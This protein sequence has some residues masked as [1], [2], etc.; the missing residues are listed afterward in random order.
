MHVVSIHSQILTEVCKSVN[1]RQLS[2]QIRFFF[3]LN[4]MRLKIIKQWKNQ[5]IRQKLQRLLKL[6][7]MHCHWSQVW[8][9]EL[10][11]EF[12]KPYKRMY[13][14]EWSQNYWIFSRKNSKTSIW[15][16]I[17]RKNDGGS[18]SRLCQ[19]Y[20]Q[21]DW[22]ECFHILIRWWNRTSNFAQYE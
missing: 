4:R 17:R 22:G 8:Y 3:R 11:M 1:H 2:E 21:R 15:N 12:Q 6:N 13:L 5:I 7:R 19:M 9:I 10:S 16:C 14:L 20:S 18:W